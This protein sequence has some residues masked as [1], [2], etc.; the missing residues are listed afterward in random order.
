MEILGN[1]SSNAFYFQKWFL[2]W[3]V[4]EWLPG[5]GVGKG[6]GIRRDV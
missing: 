2:L 4:E 3:S 1:A 5:A 6:D